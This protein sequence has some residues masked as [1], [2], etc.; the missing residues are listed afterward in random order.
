MAEKEGTKLCK[1]CKSEIPAAAKVCPHCRKKQGG[2]LK[3]IIIIAVLVVIF[4]IAIG[5]SGDGNSET[6]QAGSGTDKSM[7]AK[8]AETKTDPTSD[9]IIDVDVSDCHVKYIKHE[10]VEN[11]AGEKCLAVYYEFTNNSDESKSFMLTITDKAFQD[12]VQLESSLFH[13]NDDSK[14]S[15]VEIK[16]GVTVTVCS[17]FVLRS[18]ESDVELEVDEW[19]SFDDVEDKMILSIK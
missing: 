1:Y 7:S 6:Q 8:P 2:K 17:G 12:G 10:I 4:F 15:D 9:D 5:S 11:M 19:I 14:T 18:E 3:W 16:P 13:V